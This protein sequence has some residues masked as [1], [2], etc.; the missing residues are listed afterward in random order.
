MKLPIITTFLVVALITI[1]P[2]GLTLGIRYLP[3]GDQPSLGDTKKITQ[4]TILSQSFISP[5]DNLAGIATSIKNPNFANKEDMK[6]TILDDKDKELRALIINGRN[7]GDGNF[8]KLTFAPI[9][10]SKGKKYTF[11]FSS[12][13]SGFEN[14][15]EAFLTKDKPEW[16]LYLKENDKQRSENISFI[17]LHKVRSPLEIAP[18][19]FSSW[20]SRFTKDISF[21]I[22]Y[23]TS[24]SLLTLFLIITSSKKIN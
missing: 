12:P 7:T 11:T 2:F 3:S 21:F 15:M 4:D 20:I 1:I 17:T 13:N 14:T 19:I 24:L 23:I 18:M 10:E 8:M 22:F 9:E 16:I 6:I 5:Q